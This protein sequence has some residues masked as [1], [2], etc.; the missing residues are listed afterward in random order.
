M[1]DRPINFSPPMIRALL[2]GRKTRTCRLASS[3]LAHCR[4]GD[5][6]WV[7][8]SFAPAT[9][10]RGDW[11][12]PSAAAYVLFRDGQLRFR[13]AQGY[14]VETDKLYWR[15]TWT[16]ASL[17]PR[18]ACRSLLI[19][20]DVQICRLHD[21][22]RAEAVREGPL[23]FPLRGGPFW[24]WPGEPGLPDLS[25]VGA[26]RSSWRKTHGTAGERW[27]DN[28]E[29]VALTFRRQSDGIGRFQG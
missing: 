27:E 5:R 26:V 12:R 11:A 2:A 19:V 10:T 4:P 6:L 14:E 15:A 7:R 17:M 25:P 23:A 29:I 21:M 8:E 28:P 9:G 3:P 16:P 18:W 20:E 22:T 1:T 13:D 24:L